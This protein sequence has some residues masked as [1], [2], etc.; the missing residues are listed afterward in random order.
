MTLVEL[1]KILDVSAASISRALNRPDMVSEAMREKVLE[2]VEQYDYRPNGVA[3]SLRKG[4]TKTVGLVVSDLHNSFHSSIA[5]AVEHALSAH[6][7][8]C[9]VCD[10]DES[11]EKEQRALALLAELKVDGIIHASSGTDQGELKRLRVAGI[12]IVEIDR[13]SGMPGAGTVLLDNVL[14]SRLA[15][16]HLA[17]LGHR[18]IGMISGPER[19]TT[20]RERLRGYREAL[21]AAGLSADGALVAFGDFREESGRRAAEALLGGAAPPTALLVANN[22]MMAG[23]LTA[24]RELGLRL[25]DDLSVISF[26]DARWAQHIEPPLTVVAQPLA[27]MGAAAA[28]LLLERM[29]GREQPAGAP[30]APRRVFKPEL[31]LRAST[32]P[33]PREGPP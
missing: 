10:T 25:P 28:L 17:A 7:Y 20:G 9:V 27:E 1:A 29:T 19:L 22:E 5:K 14:G 18:R 6:G 15:V 2:A 31:I 30:P 11:R 23:A 21:V 26:D 33:P 16:E 3:R 8:S 12:P 4:E 13:A 32:A 24:I